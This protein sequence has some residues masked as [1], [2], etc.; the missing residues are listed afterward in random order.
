M[1]GTLLEIQ[2]LAKSYGARP[3]VAGV[4]TRLAAGETVALL[5]PNGSGKT[6]IL[7]CVAGLVR[8]QAGTVLVGGV[9]ARREPR[10]ARERM[11]FLP[12][13]PS[14]PKQSTVRDVLG[15]HARLRRVE[16]RRIEAALAE[17]GLGTELLGRQAGELSIGTVH[18][19]ALAVACLAEPE[20]MVLDEPTASL[21]PMAAGAFRESVRRW[22]S[23]GRGVLLATHLLADA[24]QLADRVVVLVD[25]RVAA[26]EPIGRLRERLLR[27]ALLRVAVDGPCQAHLEAA[28]AGG[29]S[30][31]RLNCSDVL[32]T[33][34]AEQR[35]EIL[36]RLAEVGPVRGLRTEEPSLESVYLD[37]VQGGSDAEVRGI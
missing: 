11:A 34:P 1:N 32:V 24:E 28:R 33:A 17:V 30:E 12:Q 16:P 26:D 3:A 21:D 25:G 10:R 35:L 20:L 13:A 19:V 9:D 29:A 6:T 22:R 23:A 2:G 4:S 15:L 8:P 36:R 5:G 7:R 18:R 14:F 27:R 37:F 31:A